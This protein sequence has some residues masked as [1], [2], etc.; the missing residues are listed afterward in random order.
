MKEHEEYT[1]QAYVFH[2]LDLLTMPKNACYTKMY[3][4]RYKNLYMYK[5][6]TM[7]K[8]GWETS[9]RM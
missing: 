4:N 8:T 9:S 3:G 5:C 7:L 6:C 2:L 1:F